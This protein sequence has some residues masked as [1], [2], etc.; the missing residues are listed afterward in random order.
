MKICTECNV[1]MPLSE[2]YVHSQMKDG[3]LNKCKICVKN[4]VNLYVAKNPEKIKFWANKYANSEKG[5]LSQSVYLQTEK[6][7]LVRKIRNDQYKKNHPLRFSA[8]TIVA[9]EISKGQLFRPLLCESCDQT[10]KIHAH[11]SDYTKPLLISWL[12]EPCHK[13]WHRENKPIYE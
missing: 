5:K 12:C 9:Y 4:R 3:H 1:Q 11:H 2:F 6:G 7:R 8:R 13:Q 10:G